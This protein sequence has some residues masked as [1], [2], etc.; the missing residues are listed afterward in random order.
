LEW[1]AFQAFLSNWAIKRVV[2]CQVYR[3]VFP[4]QQCLEYEFK[5]TPEQFKSG[6]VVV[7]DDVGK[8]SNS[9]TA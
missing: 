4:P 5:T 7:V 6:H 1:S 3:T 9:D 8:I 2:P